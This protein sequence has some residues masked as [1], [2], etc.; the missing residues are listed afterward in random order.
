MSTHDA[1]G[2]VQPRTTVPQLIV[3]AL[4]TL[5]VPFSIRLIPG[6]RTSERLSY[7]PAF[8]GHRSVPFQDYRI[9]QLTT[10]APGVVVIGDSMAGTRINERLLGSLSG[11]RVAPLLHAGSGSSFWYLALKNWVIASR[12][13]PR[14]VFIFFR[15]TN[16]TDIMFRLDDDYRW[17]LGM[18]ALDREDELNTVVQ[19]ALDGQFYRAHQAVDAAYHAANARQSVEPLLSR[20]PA[21]W[22]SG[23]Q[24]QGDLLASANDRF[25]LTHLRVMDS[26]DMATDHGVDFA[27]SV[28]RSV[29]PLMLRDA[30]Q[31]GLKL[32][33]VRVRRRPIG[34]QA[35]VQS[36]ALLRY[37]RDLR[38]YVQSH[39]GILHDETNDAEITLDMYEDG[40]HIA[41]HARDRYTRLF[42]ERL[43]L[44]F[45]AAPAAGA[46]SQPQ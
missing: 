35:P 15:D 10:L 26:A 41:R 42:F 24:G 3:I 25:G 7:L 14:I 40:D 44:L 36:P 16:L 30:R 33:F 2:G 43:R 32:C 5:A 4:V 27:A 22:V 1:G 12:V 20:A 31:A 21:A 8:A 11:L 37:A 34:G 39:G 38:A 46:S 9:G 29:L 19:A 28:D 6:A 13:K 23:P 17:S 18:V 45:R